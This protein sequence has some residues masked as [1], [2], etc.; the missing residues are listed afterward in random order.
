MPA[1]N[2]KRPWAEPRS[3][4]W[5]AR[6]PIPGRSPGS[7]SGFLTEADA[8]QYGWEQLGR[9]SRGEA[10]D[11]DSTDL[12][13]LDWVQDW[14]MRNDMEDLT[15]STK[16]TYKWAIEVVILPR[17]GQRTLAS[18][19]HAE[20]ELAAWKRELRADYADKSVNL[21]Y[22]LLT[23]LLADA[24]SADL[25][26]RDP[27]LQSR[28]RKHRGRRVRRG[29]RASEHEK[30]WTTPLQALLIAERAAA[31]TG[32]AA[33]FALLVTGAYTGMRWS[34]LIG[35]ERQYLM[36]TAVRVEWQLQ[37]QDGKWARIPPK[38]ESRRT[39]DLPGFL[40]ALLTE[41]ITAGGQCRCASHAGACY[42]WLSANQNHPFR[43]SFDRNIL[44]PAA[45]GLRYTPKYPQGRPVCFRHSE[46]PG[47]P[48]PGRIPPEQTD[49]AW[50]PILP[51]ATPHSFR[52][53]HKTLLIDLGVEE[54]LQHE[55]LGHQLP[56]MRGVY[57]HVSLPMRARLLD[58]LRSAW[59]RSLD[60]R[61]A[62][63]PRSSVPVVD[64][65]L[66]ARR[67]Q[68]THEVCS[69]SAPE[70]GPQAVTE[71]RLNTA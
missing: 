61:L 43:A 17:W 60:E 47:T 63:S 9:I 32:R 37:W 66:Q 45:E 28:Q 11:L 34:E 70:I 6:W 62:L 14:W 44:K 15:W 4:T 31:L 51:G 3:G 58:A 8:L 52:H 41:D 65:L 10:P 71:R 39:I 48:L 5:R 53:G 68:V 29:K 59:E 30:P 18:L 50:T 25:M 57:S 69:Q 19:A 40:R 38:D 26:K 22:G 13:V 1:P 46:W 35:L 24:H 36:A 42:V 20:G 49:G 7:K 27:T 2:R 64:R 54:V 33:D 67:Q 21:V 55:R 16:K 56:G 12:T 23:T